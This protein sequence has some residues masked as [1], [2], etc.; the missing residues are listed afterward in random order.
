MGMLRPR[1]MGLWPIDEIHTDLPKLSERPS[2]TLMR[3]RLELEQC[4]DFEKSSELNIAI[5]RS[6]ASTSSIDFRGQLHKSLLHTLHPLHEALR[7]H[8]YYYSRR[9]NADIRRLA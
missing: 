6:D 1:P 8:S 3:C 7:L 2:L 4:S 9:G 5:T